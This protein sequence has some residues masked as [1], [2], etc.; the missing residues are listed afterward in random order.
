MLETICIQLCCQ[1][2]GRTTVLPGIWDQPIPRVSSMSIPV[3]AMM[4]PSLGLSFSSAN[5]RDGFDGSGD[6]CRAMFWDLN[7]P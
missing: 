7:S 4:Q 6:P 5:R 2:K 3:L 1:S